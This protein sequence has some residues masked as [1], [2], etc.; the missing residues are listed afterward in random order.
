M[1]HESLDT[2]IRD[3]YDVC[4][5]GGGVA[6]IAAALAAARRGRRVLL[7]DRGFLLGGL[8]TAGL[9]TIYLPLC[10]GMGHQVS[11]GLAEELLRLSVT[12]G[13]EP[14]IPY[15]RAW[16]DGGSDE[17]KREKR[18]AV[19]YNA[20]LFAVAAEGLLQKA[21][22]EILYGSVVAAAPV[23][24]GRI[25]HIVVEGK[26]GREAFAVRTVIDATGDCD[27]AHLAGEKT[28]INAAGNPL[29]AWYY[30]YANGAYAL[31]CLGACDTADEDK[32]KGTTDQH[33]SDARFSGLDTRELSRMVQRSHAVMLQD[34]KKKQKECP[35]TLPVTYP[36]IPQV[37]MTRRL[38]GAYEI[39]DTEIGK[40]FSD[41]VGLFS[42]WRRRGPVYELPFATL[43][44]VRVKNLLCAGRC[45]SVTDAMWDIT[46]VIPVCAVSGEA[47]GVAAAMFEDFT[48]V[49]IPRL[50]EALQANGVKLH[51]E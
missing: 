32:D 31:R 43:R 24:D 19:A 13:H 21:G 22:V 40:R 38:V 51:N 3:S 12:H 7:C 23:R 16:L 20:Q 4:V 1:L 48:A 5:A 41:S 47:A 46:R 49:D 11:F 29:A 37:R 8:A 34:I 14:H 33:L 6:G 15:P 42:D 39:D 45:I 25:T 26:S 35:G 9:I 44:G 18:F 28:A 2:P 10:D 17:E 50:Q 27:V 30:S 36:T